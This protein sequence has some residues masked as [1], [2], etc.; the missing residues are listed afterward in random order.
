VAGKKTA[1]ARDDGSNRCS[2]GGFFTPAAGKRK[3]QAKKSRPE[4]RLFFDQA[5]Y[6]LAGS[7]AAGAAAGAEA[8]GAAAGAAAASAA[9]AEAAGAAAGAAA[10]SAAGAE[11]AGAATGAAGASSFLLQAA[12]ATAN[13]E[14]ISKDFFMD[15]P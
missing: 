13:R 15:F 2:T 14:M 7:E 12:R 1:G 9:G 8:A 10:A 5:D 11:A 6:F 3:F 4:G